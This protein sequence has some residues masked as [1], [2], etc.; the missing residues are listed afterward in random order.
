M[1]RTSTVEHEPGTLVT[2]IVEIAKSGRN[3]PRYLSVILETS[4]RYTLIEPICKKTTV[5]VTE[6]IRTA[7]NFLNTQLQRS[8][9]K[10]HKLISDNGK[11]YV[12]KR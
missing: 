9:V 10:V 12:S 11:E 6:H 4:T 7:I 8:G 1:N 3:G 5:N 2:D